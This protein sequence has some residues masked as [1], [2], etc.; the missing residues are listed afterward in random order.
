MSNCVYKRGFTLIETII[1]L[2]LFS[3]VI[4]GALAATMLLFEGAG[5][6]TAHARLQ[7]E[8]AF[9]LGKVARTLTGVQTVRSPL[10]GYSSTTLSVDKVIGVSADGSLVT[11]PATV[12]LEE[13]A[14]PSIAISNAGFYYASSSG[15][16]ASIYS[17]GVHFTLSLHTRQGRVV[18]RDFFATT[19]L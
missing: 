10:L 3:I 12:S 19:T 13:L 4:G 18:S 6:D 15:M 2:A 14:D 11:V 9:I 17:I 7:E 8:G 1:Y 5:R 16:G